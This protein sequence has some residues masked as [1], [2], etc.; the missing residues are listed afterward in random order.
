MKFLAIYFGYQNWSRR[1]IER[2]IVFDTIEELEAWMGTTTTYCNKGCENLSLNE[3]SRRKVEEYM[4]GSHEKPMFFKT[5][6][7][8]SWEI[9][10]T[11]TDCETFEE[12]R[13]QRDEAANQKAHDR[14]QKRLGEL[15]EQKKGWY[16]VTLELTGDGIVERGYKTFTGDV[17]AASGAEAY[18][19][20]VRECQKLA[21]CYEPAEMINSGYS[22]EFLGVLTDDGYSVEK[23]NEWKNNGV[24]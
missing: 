16:R 9:I 5:T 11:T 14:E 6:G 4:N 15:Y 10:L 2:G 12:Y 23:W 8:G 24:I 17:I 7:C 3:N 21:P 18:D 22:F 19:K 20:A 1:N 13:Q